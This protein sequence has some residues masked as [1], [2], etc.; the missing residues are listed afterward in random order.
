MIHGSRSHFIGSSPKGR[1]GRV[2]AIGW[3]I[4]GSGGAKD[5]RVQDVVIQGSHFV[6][7]DNP[8]EVA[9]ATADWLVK[10]MERWVILEDEERS[11]QKA[12]PVEQRAELSD[13]WKFWAQNIYASRQPGGAFSVAKAAK[14]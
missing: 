3:A 13:D 5:G 14:L 11:S 8:S 4:G 6:P 2:D 9:K 1:K 7:M 10:E 12:V